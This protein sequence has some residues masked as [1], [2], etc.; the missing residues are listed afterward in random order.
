MHVCVWG[1]YS[2]IVEEA[3][4]S[5]KVQREIQRRFLCEFSDSARGPDLVHAHGFLHFVYKDE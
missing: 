5:F 1:F 2:L 4:V 3:S